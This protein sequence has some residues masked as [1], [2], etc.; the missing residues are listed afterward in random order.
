[1]NSGHLCTQ[2]L[3]Y[4]QVLQ[5]QV[6]LNLCKSFGRFTFLEPGAVVFSLNGLGV[7]DYGYFA[8][9]TQTKASGKHSKTLTG[10][11]PLRIRLSDGVKLLLL[12]GWVPSQ[13]APRFLDRIKLLYVC[14]SSS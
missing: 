7:S 8:Q 12:L 3:L 10:C 4:V 11:F 5:G 6:H 13:M 14:L 2:A 1:M 9:E